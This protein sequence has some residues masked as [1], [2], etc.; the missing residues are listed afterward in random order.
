M[1]WWMPPVRRDLSLWQSHGCSYN[2]RV[3]WYLDSTS[4]PFHLHWQCTWHWHTSSLV[5]R[6][7][8]CG[9]L[10]TKTQDTTD[11]HRIR[12]YMHFLIVEWDSLGKYRMVSAW[13]FSDIPWRTRI[14]R[15]WPEEEKRRWRETW[16]M[17]WSSSS[18]NWSIYTPVARSRSYEEVW[19]RWCH[20][21]EKECIVDVSKHT[22]SFGEEA[23]RSVPPL[24]SSSV[25]SPTI[26]T[27]W[28]TSSPSTIR[29]MHLF[30]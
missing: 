17:M 9:K 15:P 3:D 10:H 27:Q 19:C 7:H 25:V 21:E 23:S 1:W 12:E 14:H 16:R 24:T 28:K 2:R 11:I 4:Q 26:V 18:P 20:G 13:R 6:W 29:E 30:L 5:R 22:L 8:Y